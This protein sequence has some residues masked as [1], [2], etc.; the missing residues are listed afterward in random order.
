MY[1]YNVYQETHAGTTIA[2][3]IA[4]FGF[5][6]TYRKNVLKQL[7]TKHGVYIGMRF[8]FVSCEVVKL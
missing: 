7:S 8:A 3:G 6:L 4:L 5:A 1:P 2:G